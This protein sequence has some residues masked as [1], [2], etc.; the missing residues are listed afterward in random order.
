MT[1]PLSDS[2]NLHLVDSSVWIPIYG[3]QPPAILLDRIEDLVRSNTAAVNEQIELEILIAHKRQD[4]FDRMRGAL[5]ALV[6]L[7][8]VSKAWD[9]AARLGFDLRRKGLAV[10]TPD[11]L[12]AA[13]ALEHGAILLHADS[14]FDLIARHAPLAVES[15][16][17]AI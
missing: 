16:L 15:Y 17:H 8:I 5:K 10:V 11:L 3:R 7:P 14:D 4:D 6:R 2:G 13:S 12:I 9:G 1:V